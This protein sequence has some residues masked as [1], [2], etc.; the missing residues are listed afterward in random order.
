MSTKSVYDEPIHTLK[1]VL[2]ETPDVAANLAYAV[3]VGPH[4]RHTSDDS[5][6]WK[7]FA[8]AGELP[9]ELTVDSGVYAAEGAVDADFTRVLLRN[10]RAT[11]WSGKAA[12]VYTLKPGGKIVQFDTAFLNT[13]DAAV[14]SA[15]DLGRPPQPGDVLVIDDG[16]TAVTR[17]VFRIMGAD[18]AAAIGSYEKFGAVANA[19]TD[20]T[21]VSSSVTFASSF[22][23][24]AIDANVT[25]R[26]FRNFG[27]FGAHDGLRA[28]F[29]IEC[30]GGGADADAATF[31][32]RVNGNTVGGTVA[33]SVADVV[34]S[35]NLP[36][37]AFATPALSLTAE[38]A[39]PW[40]AGN[41][42]RLY[43]DYT[44]DAF[45][46][47]GPSFFDAADIAGYH[48]G[49]AIKKISAQ[50]VYTVVGVAENG[51]V[52][53]RVESVQG[54]SAAQLIT[55][56]D[57]TDITVTLPYDGGA[58]EFTLDGAVRA[59]AYTGL[60]VAALITPPQESTTLFDKVELNA[61][62]GLS[63]AVTVDGYYAFTGTL[64]PANVLDA[65]YVATAT[66]ITFNSPSVA[67]PAYPVV[68]WKPLATSGETAVIWRE[69]VA[70]ASNELL[71]SVR[72]QH[73]IISILGSDHPDSELG[74][75]A[76]CALHGGDNQEIYLVRTNGSTL[77]DF[78]EAFRKIERQ[79]SAYALAVLT[80]DEDIK[81]EAVSHVHAMS[82][83]YIKHFRRVYVGTDSPGEYP[84]IG[85]RSDESPYLA[86]IAAG[87]NGYNLV[88]ATSEDLDFTDVSVGDY[89][90][91]TAQNARYRITSVSPETLELASGPLAPLVETAIQIIAADTAENTI[92]YVAAHTVSLGGTKDVDRRV[93]NVWCDRPEVSVDGTYQ[94]QGMRFVA[95]EMAGARAA[96]APHQ[97]LTR[98]GVGSIHRAPNMYTKL[99][100]EHLNALGK[101]GVWTITQDAPESRIY[102]RHQ[103]TTAT[104]G[105]LLYYEDSVG[106]N[107][108]LICFEIDDV[109]EPKIG[110]VNANRRSLVNL[111]AELIDLLARLSTEEDTPDGRRLG[112]RIERFFNLNNV[113][114]TISLSLNPNLKDQ[115]DHGVILELPA[116]LNRVRSV[117]I[118]RPISNADGSV[119]TTLTASP[120]GASVTNLVSSTQA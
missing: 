81:Q 26:W 68:T 91:I 6:A 33:Q 11:L 108:D 109:I 115:F 85:T 50:V 100:R 10:G 106:T 54:L 1:Q 92:K 118:G 102:V 60:K 97:G 99:R 56:T 113:P 40:V 45:A 9:Y 48:L 14:A 103:L 19:A 120:A 79:R 22:A 41:L 7:T 44:A 8:P 96:V 114:D 94:V 35:F 36:G 69:L 82:S 46:T 57:A 13:A 27:T 16:A 23:L 18:T 74:Y 101:A 38:F 67:V 51:D 107:L 17:K 119:V 83:E 15:F 88:V 3:V 4:Y 78:Q 32:L 39:G 93:A 62:T 77:A 29:E 64:A 71:I 34:A 31:V 53:L 65:N 73:E 49:N 28:L 12:E 80:Q 30:T 84:L 89:V 5:L 75:G 47:P 72:G 63:G 105:G 70:P 117:V 76:L 116:P 24:A 37:I 112:S 43:V 66:E 52:T 25:N 110:A 111:N 104:E 59:I 2:E 61:V 95:A 42:V 55:M 87:D 90:L 86:N 21:V 20:V 98:R 58:V